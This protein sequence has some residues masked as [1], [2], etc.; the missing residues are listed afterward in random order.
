MNRKMMKS[1]RGEVREAQPNENSN[2]P[3]GADPQMK[4]AGCFH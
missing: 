1:Q 4:V 3:P 2:R